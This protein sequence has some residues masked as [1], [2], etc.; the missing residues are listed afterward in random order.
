MSS[1]LTHRQA[2]YGA[3]PGPRGYQQLTPGPGETHVARTELAALPADLGEALLTVAHLSDIHVC[4]AQSPARAEF[5]DR[6]ADPDSPVRDVLSEVGTYRAQEFLNM[7][8][9]DAMVRAVNEVE[10]GP[11]GGAPVDFAISTGDNTDNAQLNE[12]GWYLTVF[13][14]GE[15]VPDSGDPER[16]EGVA[17][18]AHFDDRFWHPETENDDLPRAVHGFPRVP[19]LLDAARARFTAPGLTRPWLAVHGNHDQMVQGTWPGDG[20]AGAASVAAAK[21]IAL[22]LEQVPGGIV[23]LMMRLNQADPTALAVLEQAVVQEVTPDARRRII[24]R[25]EFVAAHFGD[26]AQPS[27]HGFTAER[28]AYYRYDHGAVTMLV[29]DTVNEYGGY[30]GSLDLEQLEWLDAELTAADTDRRY[31]VLASHHPVS[32]LVNDRVNGSAGRRVLGDELAAMLSGHPSLVLWLNGHTHETAVTAHDGWWEVTAPSLIDWPQQARIVE[33]LRSPG[34]LTIAA[35]MIDHA[36]E[37]PWSG[38]I[39]GT[40]ALAGLSRELAA[41][42]WQWRDQP[43]HEHPRAGERDERNVLLPLPDPWA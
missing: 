34:T 10:L 22:D 24:T 16:Y 3:E 41:N 14:G 23:E 40:T 5:L 20:P 1:H 28:R 30:D 13:E 25:D 33:L 32:T 2:L 18:G 15:L 37:A 38:A 31:V 6:W 4:D 21:T 42:D 27:G 11:M 7:Q 39:E 9:A 19:G 17:S 43:L 35:T 8:V 29:L 12:L 36:G 26:S